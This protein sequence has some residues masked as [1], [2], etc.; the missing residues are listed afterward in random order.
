MLNNKHY[1]RVTRLGD[2]QEFK[3]VFA[4]STK[5][6][7]DQ[8]FFILARENNLGYPRLG[9]AVSKKKIKRAVRRNL[10]KRIIREQF[11]L[12]QHQLPAV[13]MVVM[14]KVALCHCEKSTIHQA[15]G[16]LWLRLGLQ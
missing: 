4:D 7:G 1:F 11:R 6:C 12:H 9:M 2:K 5:K 3:Q 14:A 10:I 15:L 16:S 8:Y 13:D